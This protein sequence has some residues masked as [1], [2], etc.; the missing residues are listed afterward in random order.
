M[1]DPGID[2]EEE[3]PPR[4]AEAE[5]GTDNMKRNGWDVFV[6]VHVSMSAKETIVRAGTLLKVC[7]CVL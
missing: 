7:V 5:R 6:S 1:W 4:A 2:L 3:N